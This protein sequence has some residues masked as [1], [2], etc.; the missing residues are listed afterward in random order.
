[1]VAKRLFR[2]AVIAALI[3]GS[4]SGAHADDFPARPITMIIT[5]AAGGITDVVARIYADVASRNMGQRIIVDNR[6]TGGGAVAALAV[7]NAP[8]DGYTLLVFAGAQH[9]ALPAMQPVAYQP[10]SGFQPVTILFNLVNFLAVPKDSPA[11]SAA[12]LIELG[13]KKPG[14]LSFGSAGVGSPAHL[15]AVRMA[16]ATNTPIEYVQYRG[17]APMMAD[18]VSGRL[19]F[20]LVSYT[21]AGPFVAEGKLRILA[22]DWKTRWPDLPDV[23]TLE[24]AGI[25]HEKVGSWF[26]LAA[27]AGTPNGVV[28]KLNAEFVKAS[29]DPELI[30]RLT[31]NGA[32]VTT[33]TPKE[34][35]ALLA[36]EVEKTGEL[37][38]SLGLR[39]Q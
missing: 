6:P 8:P 9:A 18:L 37:V 29:R 23:P 10:V 3:L 25:R 22:V 30:K 7:Q 4:A 26:A 16:R 33:S 31:A 34:M 15:N 24:E 12:E 39:A 38:R 20:S 1:M 13:R 2:Y 14:G 28:E 36:D 17:S 35:S 5:F 21:G 11:N 27:P 32:A 19:D